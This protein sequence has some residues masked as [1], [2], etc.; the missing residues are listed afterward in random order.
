MD[1][2]INVNSSWLA[3]SVHCH[4]LREEMLTLLEAFA[5][6]VIDP[7][8]GF[9]YLDRD[10]MPLAVSTRD[11]VSTGRLVY[12]F[13]VA[14]IF[15]V[16]KADAI[17]DHGVTYLWNS[18]RD[19]RHGGYFWELFGNQNDPFNKKAYGHAFVLLGAAAATRCGH[20]VASRLLEDVLWVIDN[21][22]WRESDSLHVDSCTRDWSSTAP[23]RGQNSNMHLVEALMLTGQVLGNTEFCDRAYRIAERIIGEFTR[24]NDWRLSEHYDQTWT[25]DRNYNQGAPD[26][27]YRPHGSLPGHWLEWSPGFWW[28]ST[29]VTRTKAGCS[30]PPTSF[31][32]R[33]FRKDGTPNKVD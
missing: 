15:G 27:A 26:D 29:D 33:P 31:L 28:T 17:V 14:Q 32:R 2:D 21:R 13:S 24:K 25:I 22:F 10:F 8:G 6:H 11:A 30:K 12:C 16:P 9:Y 5:N 1:S 18:F 20:P 7:R 23:Y 4:W 19:R 3:S